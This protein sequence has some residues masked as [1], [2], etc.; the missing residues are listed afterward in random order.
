MDLKTDYCILGGGMIGSTIAIG[1]SSLG[2]KV[3]VIE[4][5]K[6]VP[7]ES[8]VLPDLRVSALN[9]YTQ[10]LLERYGVWDKVEKMRCKQY[11]RL[12][13]WEDINQPLH[14]EADEIGESYLG[15][16]V[17]NRILQL[18]L[19]ETIAK[20]HS[21]NISVMYAQATHIDVEKAWLSLNNSSTIQAATLVGAD[22]GNSQLRQAANI[23]STGWQYA[24]QA[25]VILVKM[26][27]NF[28]AATWQQ[29]TPQGPIAFLPLFDG[30][31]NL[32]WYADPATSEQIKNASHTDI[33]KRILQHFPSILGEFDVLDK[34]GFPLRRMHANKYWRSNAVLV[35]DAAHQ[36][37]PLAGQ[38]VNLGFK[39]VDALVESIKLNPITDVN[40]EA[41]VNYER[42][43]RHSNLTMMSAMDVFY[44]TFSNDLSPIKTL[45]NIGLNIANAAG[46]FKQKALKYAMGIE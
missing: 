17:E 23:G 6:P 9:R 24:Q 22:G 46:P 37:N 18:A 27:A 35:G 26:A 29:F 31:A 41:L 38:G 15:Y 30:Y 43:R 2:Y 5:N 45:R 32:V 12:S 13:V 36:I 39:D 33:K 20:E 10:K 44:Q 1:L 21:H 7:Y 4:A 3:I 25:N 34:T 14:F 11:K 28:E 16:F 19:L 42:A 8:S 40:K